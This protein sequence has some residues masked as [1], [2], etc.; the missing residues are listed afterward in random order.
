M[1]YRTANRPAG[2][3]PRCNRNLRFWG[4]STERYETCPHCGGAFMDEPT[5]D[6]LCAQMRLGARMPPLHTITGDARAEAI[7]RCPVCRDEMTKVF[8]AGAPGEL[9][10]LDRC[11]LHGIWFDRHELEMMLEDVAR[12][13]VDS[14]VRAKDVPDL[15]TGVGFVADV[16]NWILEFTS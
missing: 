5:L 11:D 3:C 15:L 13:P 14:T 8:P 2:T 16:L 7:R 9:P 10:L 4:T 12:T 6:A 1:S